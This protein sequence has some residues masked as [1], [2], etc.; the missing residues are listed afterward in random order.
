MRARVGRGLTVRPVGSVQLAI[1]IVGAGG[2]VV[3]GA[4]SIAVAVPVPPPDVV[5][6]AADAE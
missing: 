6:G 3:G 1:A 4:A 2:V 5:I